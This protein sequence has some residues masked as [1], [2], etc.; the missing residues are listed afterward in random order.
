MKYEKKE[1]LPKKG[2]H[3]MTR[4]KG[5]EKETGRQIGQQ[6]YKEKVNTKRRKRQKQ[7]NK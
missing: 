5:I 1:T 3:V 6:R 4:M 7:K 2:T